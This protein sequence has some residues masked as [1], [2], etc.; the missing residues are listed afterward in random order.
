MQ[1]TNIRPEPN[2]AVGVPEAD[3]SLYGKIVPI[4]KPPG[5]SSFGVV[6][7]IRKAAGI[8]KVGHAGTLDP[9]AEG[10]LLVGI[11]RSA[12]RLLGEF[13]NSDKEYFAR[14][15][16]GIVT[17]TYDPTGQITMRNSFELPGEDTISAVLSEFEG[18]ILQ[19]PPAFSAVKVNGMRMYKAARK[20]IIL[21]P[22]PRKVTI[23]DIRLLGLTPDGFEMQVTC[24]HGT[25]IR[26]LANDLG[27]KL[28]PGAHLSR[29]IRTRVGDYTL[30]QAYELDEF[31]DGLYA[32]DRRN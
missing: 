15:V 31:V 14:V 27:S 4:N 21:S 30:E 19:I 24:S 22:E 8:K 16:L 6:S 12:T 13:L 20:G 9:F 17:D 1:A 28:G 18:E 32:A 11:G 26:S 25:Y 10:L 7:R 29:L 23:R 2:K 3:R 5:I